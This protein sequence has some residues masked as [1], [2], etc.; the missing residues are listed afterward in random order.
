MLEGVQC[1]RCHGDSD[2][3]LK[4]VRTGDTAGARMPGL[5]ELSTE[6][7]SDFCG[8]CHRTW[9]Q[10]AMIGPRGIG[11]I[12]FQPYRLQ[13][14]KCYDA[15][16]RR[17]RCTACHDPHSD[18]RREPADYDANCKACHSRDAV[19]PTKAASHICRV[20]A[21]NCVTC[22]MPQ[23]ELPGAHK[24]FSDHEIRIARAN[25]KYPD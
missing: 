6:E 19:P 1:E 23:L 8:E 20:S 2:R 5:A 18:V 15:E 25:E 12:R 10:I 9:S 16:D 21:K 17:I 4:A 22:H 24:K 13:S 7:M 11:N 3:H 14:S